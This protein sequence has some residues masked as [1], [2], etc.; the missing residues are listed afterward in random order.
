MAILTSPAGSVDIP[1][2]SITEYMLRRVDEHPDKPALIDG[3]TGRTL[4]YGELREAIYHV[5][6]GLAETGFSKSDVLAVMAPNLPEYA[7]AF[8]AVALL[9]GVVTTINPTYT[10]HEVLHQLLDA[11]ATHLVTIG[12]FLDTAREAAAGTPVDEIYTF[13][14]AEGSVPFATLMGEARIAEQVPV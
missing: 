2:V 12:M 7:V 11:G 3:M 14:G 1:D 6:G 13:D 4:T 8:H 5:A 10:A 9:G